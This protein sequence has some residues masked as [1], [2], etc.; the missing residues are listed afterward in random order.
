MLRFLRK[1]FNGSEFLNGLIPDLAVPPKPLQIL[2]V[3]EE[4]ARLMQTQ[5]ISQL[6]ADVCQACDPCFTMTETPLNI[7]LT[8][9]LLHCL[10]NKDSFKDSFKKRIDFMFKG[11][12]IEISR[13]K[14]IL[15][16]AI[17]ELEL[18][19]VKYSKKNI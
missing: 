13:Q 5:M 4:W 10:D 7:S 8:E 15:K 2:T 19:E 6:P 12:E 14:K 16:N 1:L 17:R 9:F 3:F 11:D 18:L